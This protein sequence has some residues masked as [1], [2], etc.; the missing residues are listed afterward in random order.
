M[1]F[2]GQGEVVTRSG[3]GA[4]DT[5]VYLRSGPIYN[6]HQ[7]DDQGNLLVDAYGGELLVENAGSGSQ[8]RDGLPQQ[9]PCRRAAI[10]F[11]TATTRFSARGRSPERRRSADGSRQSSPIP[12]IHYVATDFSNAYPDAVV[13]A[14]KT[15]KVTREVVTILPD[16]VVVRDRVT[17]A[18]PEVLFHVWSGGGALNAGTRELAILHGGGHGWLKTIFPAN[19]TAQLSAQ[20]ATDL[21][22]I[23]SA[24]SGSTVDFLH[25]VY[26][27]PASSRF[28]PGQLTSIDTPSQIGASFV[29]RQGQRWS[30][31][32]QKNGVGLAS[33]TSGAALSPPTGL[34]VVR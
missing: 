24:S 10:R 31:A 23:R 11:R 7:H 21:L 26:V 6:G 5:W 16:V 8:P 2:Q 29:D 34:R 12:G 14:P 20:G 3:F 15:G 17:G 13:P 18:N 33:V 25:I 27:S 30:V 9:H 22:T 4:E 28:V 19:A 32:F 1:H